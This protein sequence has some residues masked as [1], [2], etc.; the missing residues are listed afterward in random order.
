MDPANPPAGVPPLVW[1]L[2]FLIG[3]PGV[4]GAL[5][6]KAAATLP[7]IFGAVGR[8]W[9]GRRTRQLDAMI[10]A[11]AAR[12]DDAEIARLSRRYESLA[13]DAERDRVRYQAEIGKCQ[14]RLDQFEADFTAEKQLRW[15]AVGH[16]RVL[17]DSHRKHA[18][19]AELPALPD[20]LA[21]II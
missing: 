13:A 14:H 12:I 17:A 3:G 9:Q 10:H 19:D 20:K 21:D 4:F 1:V 11:D 2:I 5:C 18:P 15:V 7:G 16:I 6:T 8:W